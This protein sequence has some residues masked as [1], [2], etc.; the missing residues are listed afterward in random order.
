MPSQI[1]G[2]KVGFVGAGAMAEALAKGFMDKQVIE[3]GDI[4]CCDPSKAR[5]DVFA[6]MGCNTVKNAAE[7]RAHT[8]DCS[9]LSCPLTCSFPAPTRL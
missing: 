5:M 9:T 3:S 7:V 8:L 2:R 1:D 6:D 4:W